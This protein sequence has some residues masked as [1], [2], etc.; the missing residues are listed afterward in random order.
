MPRR[1]RPEG[2]V[3]SSGK[4]ARALQRAIR[5]DNPVKEPPTMG[6]PVIVDS[7]GPRRTS[8]R[9]AGRKDREA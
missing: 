1:I 2:K 6:K 7:P 5:K 4:A 3:A 8:K 9:N